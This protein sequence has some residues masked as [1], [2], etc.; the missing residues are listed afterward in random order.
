MKGGYRFRGFRGE[1]ENRVVSFDVPSQMR[2]P[3]GS[4][5]ESL[6]IRGGDHVEAGQVLASPTDAVGSPVICT[7]KGSAS[8]DEGTVVV[9][10]SGD[11]ALP[12]LDAQPEWENLPP[13][14]LE[15]RLYRTGSCCAAPSG[16]PT[17]HQSSPVG[18]KDIEQ[19]IVYFSTSDLYGT[20][21]ETIL[22][23]RGAAEILAGIAILQKIMTGAHAHIVVGK[24]D[25]ALL[26][27]LRE[28][29]AATTNSIS[30]HVSANKY[31]QE[32]E[33]V[34]V[35]SV[36]DRDYPYG[37]AA[38]HSGVLVID[39]RGI[40]QVHD[41]LVG[42]RLFAE[43]LIA[44]HGAGFREN[45]HITVRIGTPIQSIVD[46]Y[47][48][49]GVESR[50]VYNSVMSGDAVSDPG[51]TVGSD[52]T[53]IIALPVGGNELLP[54]ASPGLHKDSI[55]RTFVA[56]FLPIRVDADTNLHGEQRPCLSCG[57]CE[58]VCP[59]GLLPYVLHRYVQRD[60]VDEK[61]VRYGV[62][63]CVD[64]NLCSYVCPS[65]IPLARLLTEGKRKLIDEG[66]DPAG[67]RAE[68]FAL[69]GIPRSIPQS[70]E[71]ER[72]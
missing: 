52:C 31:P 25:D 13:E 12:V 48:V 53:A 38:I 21:P 37:F 65:K 23:D 17:R 69:K 72:E 44:I 26:Q 39:L 51:A 16:I 34:L 42:G 68:K 14:D 50:I 35:A 11:Q 55:T 32:N 28:E 4:L 57:Y 8:L 6:E 1:A 47:G 22:G 19:I 64:C 5:T 41:A 30:L 62:F 10:T 20:K 9:Q 7:A 3:I 2:F 59:V 40:L 27:T 36:L 29:S 60:M 70:E 56:S 58:Q 15:D 71:A 54:F 63:D 49:P 67:A 61:L 43:R 33:A 66:L 18:P 24:G 46:A 45:V